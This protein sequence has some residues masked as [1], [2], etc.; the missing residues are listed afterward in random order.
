MR[1]RMPRDDEPALSPLHGSHFKEPQFQR[2]MP[3]SRAVWLRFTDTERQTVCSTKGQ[4]PTVTNQAAAEGSDGAR[5][6]VLRWC[7]SLF[8]STFLCVG[9]LNRPSRSLKMSHV[10][11]F[12]SYVNVHTRKSSGIR[13]T[14]RPLKTWDAF[15]S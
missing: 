11:A 7:L 10:S 2:V 8:V 14:S 12:V 5:M 15:W 13:L 4:L 6:C 1:G 9:T 3:V